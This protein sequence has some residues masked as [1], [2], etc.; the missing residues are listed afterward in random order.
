MSIVHIC[1][2]FLSLYVFEEIFFD[3]VLKCVDVVGGFQ[4]RCETV[5]YF[6]PW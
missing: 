1:V 5:P 4:V 2:I 6:G 3:L